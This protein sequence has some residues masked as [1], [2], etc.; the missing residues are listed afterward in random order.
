M[1]ECLLAAKMA[2]E[3]CR[4]PSFQQHTP[5]QRVPR[6]NSGCL[7][8]AVHLHLY[9]PMQLPL[10]ASQGICILR[11]SN[12]LRGTDP[13]HKHSDQ[14]LLP[15]KGQAL[16]TS[17]TCGR[18][19]SQLS[20]SQCRFP[21]CGHVMA[22]A[23]PSQKWQ[24]KCMCHKDDRLEQAAS[25]NGPAW[26][27]LFLTSPGA[28]RWPSESQHQRNSQ[29]VKV[30][31]LEQKAKQGASLSS[32]KTR[33]HSQNPK[34]STASQGQPSWTRGQARSLTILQQNKE[35]LPEPHCN[36]SILHMSPKSSLE[37]CGVAGSLW[38]AK[39]PPPLL[40]ALNLNDSLIFLQF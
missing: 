11:P 5:S 39:G 40:V 3:W 31:P 21:L 27:D 34:I 33:R 17:V 30:N 19:P 23:I 9:T 37:G 10:P 12:G 24:S 16:Q 29:R 25:L 22:S 32:N 7:V 15:I 14:V 28:S 8:P 1:T 2:T 13:G 6:W 18:L 38:K 4:P 36:L 20:T 26:R 35:T